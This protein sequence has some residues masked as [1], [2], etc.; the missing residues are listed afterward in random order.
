MLKDGEDLEKIKKYT[1]LTAQW[2]G[3]LKNE[4]AKENK[5]H[6]LRISNNSKGL[7]S[8][9]KSLKKW[10]ITPKKSMICLE[11]TGFYGHL[12]AQWSVENKYDTWM[13]NSLDIKKS[14]GLTRGQ[15]D[16]IDTYRIAPLCLSI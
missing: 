2:L 5:Q 1:G 8:L 4:L 7:A 13:A 10:G 12:L 15:N 3:R 6:T 16:V 9:K 14:L 11:N